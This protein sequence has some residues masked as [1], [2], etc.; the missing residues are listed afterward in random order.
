MRVRVTPE[1]LRSRAVRKVA[2]LGPSPSSPRDAARWREQRDS[3]LVYVAALAD[4]DPGLL[5]QA[6]LL[7]GEPRRGD[8]PVNDLLFEASDYC[9]NTGP[10]RK[11]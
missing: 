10:G 9:P 11:P 5:R 1:D 8:D 3:A 2:A 6:A 4:W 7:V